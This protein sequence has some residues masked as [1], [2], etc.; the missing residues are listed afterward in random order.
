MKMK[1]MLNGSIGKFFS[2][3]KAHLNLFIEIENAMFVLSNEQMLNW[4]DT[5]WQAFVDVNSVKRK[6]KLGNFGLPLAT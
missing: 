4:L 3:L 6:K 1:Q 5:H 2:A